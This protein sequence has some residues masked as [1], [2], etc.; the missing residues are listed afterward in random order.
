MKTDQS[1]PSFNYSRFWATG[2][3]VASVAHPDTILS[4]L[5][6]FMGCVLYVASYFEDK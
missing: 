2:S 5:L 1:T 3:L 6:I 4:I